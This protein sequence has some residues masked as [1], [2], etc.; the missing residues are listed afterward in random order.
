MLWEGVCQGA[1]EP[2]PAALALT[3]ADR[4]DNWGAVPPFFSVNTPRRK[5]SLRKRKPNA[6]LP[7]PAQPHHNFS[8]ARPGTKTEERNDVDVC[9]D[10]DPPSWS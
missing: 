9:D 2:L 5:M 6:L 7:Q 8:L 4:A 10:A 3:V 1:L